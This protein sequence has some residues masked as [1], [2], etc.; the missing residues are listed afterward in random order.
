MATKKE[1][2][3]ICTFKWG[4]R[5]VCHEIVFSDDQT[6]HIACMKCQYLKRKE[7]LC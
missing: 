2:A 1:F 4:K 7:I 6:R 5:E 3:N